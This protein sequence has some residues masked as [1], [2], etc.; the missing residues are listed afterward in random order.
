MRITRAGAPAAIDSGGTSSVT[1]ELAPMT[2]RSPIVTPLVTT[3]LAPHHTLSPMPLGP[4]EVNPCQGTGRPGSSK[5][6]LP[7]DTKQPLANM[8]W[9]PISTRSSAATSRRC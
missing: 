7:S 5:R 1:T 4:F 9:A 2:Q 6:W 8:Q 3:T